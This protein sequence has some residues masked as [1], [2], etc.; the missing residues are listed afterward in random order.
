MAKPKKVTQKNKKTKKSKFKKLKNSFLQIGK[1]YIFQ[2]NL[3]NFKYPAGI[4]GTPHTGILL[5]VNET[6]YLI[7]QDTGIIVLKRE[8][9]YLISEWVDLIKED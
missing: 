6:E 9:V 7:E 1:K 8:L 2:V 5:G 3:P 4:E